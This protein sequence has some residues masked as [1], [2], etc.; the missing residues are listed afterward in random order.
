LKNGDR[1]KETWV[2]TLRILSAVFSFWIFIRVTNVGK[3]QTAI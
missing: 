3:Y 1:K 2:R